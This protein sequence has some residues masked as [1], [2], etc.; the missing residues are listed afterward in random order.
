M[1]STPFTFLKATASPPPPPVEQLFTANG[2]WSC[3]TGAV[4]IEVIAI[5]AG[6]C[7][8]QGATI[9]SSTTEG[10]GG[11]GGGGAGGVSISTFSSGFGSTQ[12]IIV[13]STDSCFGSLVVAKRGCNGANG[14]GPT[15]SGST[16]LGGQGGT[17]NFAN[18]GAG[19]NSSWDS[20]N[21]TATATNGS[22]VGGGAGGR[23]VFFRFGTCTFSNTASGGAGSTICGLARGAGGNGT[24]S[25]GCIGQTYGGGGAGGST[26]SF[27][28]GAGG[29]G[30][31]KVIQYFS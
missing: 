1:F 29:P 22:S 27:I 8:G 5:G 10:S 4:C 18:G 23:S 26:P 19:G 30:V 12:C 17:G 7:G 14:F 25:T 9:G 21:L 24:T 2:T 20:A 11:G 15:F 16:T 6:G 3:C 31:V 13:G 28:G